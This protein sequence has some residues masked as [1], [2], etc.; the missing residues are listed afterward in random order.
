MQIGKILMLAL[1]MFFIQVA[2]LVAQQPESESVPMSFDDCLATIRAT[3]NDL[4]I[5][6]VN[7]VETDI[8]RIV[9]FCTSDG[10]VLVSCSRPDSVM[11]LTRSPH[12]DG[13]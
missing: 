13:C 1:C 2:D 5:A 4:R 9:R 10:S 8:L 6:P 11:V 12:R 3:A 7:I